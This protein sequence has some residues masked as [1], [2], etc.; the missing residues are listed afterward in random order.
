LQKATIAGASM[1]IYDREYYRGET[2]GSAWLTGQTPACTAIIIINVV[3]FFLIKDTGR[4]DDLYSMLSASS[5]GVFEQGRI[6]QLVTATFLHSNHD[7]FHLVW[8]MVFLWFFGREVEALYGSRDFLALY[9]TAGAISTLGWAAVAQFDSPGRTMVGASGA[10]AAVIVLYTLYNPHRQFLI[11][12]IIPME[13]WMIVLIYLGRDLYQLLFGMSFH[14]VAV[15]SHLTGA[16]Y[17]YL[18]KH[19]DLRWSRFNWNR[20]RRPRL[21]IVMPEPREKPAPRPSGP[22]WSANPGGSP[23]PATTAVLPEEQ[24]DAKLDEVL[25]KIAREGRDGLTEEEN[26]VLQEASRRARNRRSDRI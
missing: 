18:Y 22:T 5:R 3:V 2:G 10:V 6:W 23:K 4:P 7:M 14:Q 13:M 25:A 12:F 1:G 15:A 8:N 26:R 16:A 20:V 24:L 17:G 9:L 19:F 11:F 21:R